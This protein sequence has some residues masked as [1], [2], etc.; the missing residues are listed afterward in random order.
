MKN[1]LHYYLAVIIFSL[2]IN[3][4]IAQII[5]GKVIEHDNGYEISGA[6]IR[7]LPSGKT[8]VSLTEGQYNLTVD[9]SDTALLIN[10]IAY[11]EQF[12]LLSD[13]L[14]RSP[15]VIA[16][17]RKLDEIDEIVI[18]SGYQ[19]IPKERSTGSFSFVDNKRFN[20]K[21]G[22]NV[23]D[24]LPGIANGVT[25]D[26]NTTTGGMMIRGL[27]TIRGPKDILIILDNF[28]FEG[29][30]NNINPNDVE[31]VTILKDAAASSI[32]GARAGNGVIV[33]TTKK[34]EMNSATSI[35]ITANTTIGS[36][37]NIDYL[38]PI[39]TADY[40]EAEE[41][42]FE[43]GHYTSKINSPGQPPLSPIVEMLLKYNGDLQDPEYS[44]YRTALLGLD[45][46]DQYMKHFYNNP[47]NQQYALTVRGGS[48]RHAWYTSAGYDANRDVTEH[49]Y[50]RLNMRISNTFK[51]FEKM[52]LFT[53]LYYTNSL[54][55]NGK[56][57][58]GEIKMGTSDLYP[59]AL[60]ADEKGVALPIYQYRQPYI[61]SLEGNGLLDWKY[62]PLKDFKNHKNSVSLN[63][64]IINTGINIGKFFGL[65]VDIKYQY[66]V[67]QQERTN[68]REKES[69]FARNLV[70]T[71]TQLNNTTG[72]AIYVVP[73]G[74][75][76]DRSRQT[77]QLHN[78]RAQLDYEW[79][80]A[81]H[82]INMIAG[83]EVR[84]SGVRGDS[85]RTY[86]YNPDILT[87]GYVDYLEQY[88]EYISGNRSYIPS[89]NSLTRLRTRF[90][91][92]YANGAYTY[93]GRYSLSGSTRRD[94]SNL[95]G[96][97]TNDRW[98]M[99]WS[100]GASWNVH[101]EVFYGLKIIPRL[102]LRATY[103]FSGNIDPAMSAVTTIAYMGNSLVTPGYPT[104]RFDNFAN[105]DLR[106]ETSR[107]TNLAVDFGSIGNRISG[108]VDFYYKKGENLFGDEEMDVTAGVGRYAVK[109]AAKIK[110]KGVDI[111][112]NSINVN[113]GNFQWRSH[114]NFNLNSDRVL[115]YYLLSRQASDFIASNTISGLVDHPIYSMFSYKWAGLNPETGSPRGV[116]GSEIT[117][118][119]ANLI[120]SATV[121]EMNYHGPLLP[122]SFGSL[123]NTFSY[124]DWELTFRF[125]FKMGHFFRRSSLQYVD[126]FNLGRGHA[127]Y[128]ARWRN[129]GDENYT[130]VPA[131]AYPNNSLSDL[132]YQG[133]EPLVEKA[134]HVR[135]QYIN[136]S[137]RF[138][139]LQL[140]KIGVKQIQFFANA[141]NL[142]VIW[143]ANKLGLDPDFEGEYI[144]P[145][146]KQ[147][148]FGIRA[149]L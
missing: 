85:Y 79:K 105:P 74:G 123:G 45:V 12:I 22:L 55:N 145:P 146:V 27:S 68:L 138:S 48:T 80:M 136:F 37:P 50:K 118:E 5:K 110:G 49:R 3:N 15:K 82:E 32:W 7:A 78:L 144:M 40:I 42:L 134:D 29:D 95:F 53:E 38:R 39:S 63:D 129:P 97:N 104:A 124:K 41:F 83:S 127:D 58:F 25:D 57:A 4:S 56:P 106:W 143:R 84:S 142:G 114:M 94:A 147:L 17:K 112:V 52:R 75:V 23:L 141:N 117:E 148:A 120:Y 62:Y 130:N 35:D 47:V 81:D 44:S 137:Y 128:A 92:A 51:P 107:M 60:F 66:K 18:S 122:I 133:A 65:G 20:E 90:V 89:G 102:R 33:I 91:S 61:E 139:N 86:G 69:Y 115:E 64:L 28:P 26:N 119:Y 10:H 140:N 6:S 76:I 100:I 2:I 132:F 19:A 93:R 31:S 9:Q 103:G 73:L 43:R 14:N 72:Q 46:R 109:N 13:F 88:P 99:L 77:L 113:R 11:V 24:R 126:L 111:E 34:G 36:L 125:S 71:Y 21:I 67:Q 16:L 8:T 87:F 121:D 131:M 98:N 149:T 116:Y 59:Y 108:S 101:Q 54:Q 70:N 1:Y 96:L 30:L 135:L